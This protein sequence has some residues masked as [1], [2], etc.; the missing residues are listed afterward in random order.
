MEQSLK[1]IRE[2]LKI[3]KGCDLLS[4][5]VIKTIVTIIQEDDEI[6]HHRNDHEYNQEKY[7]ITDDINIPESFKNACLETICEIALL[8]PEL[9]CHS[10]GF[11]LII[12]CIFEKSIEISST[13][14]MVLLKILDF[15]NS[16][17]FIRNGFDLDSLISIYSNLC[18]NDDY[19]SSKLKKISSY[20]LQKISFL[21]S[22]LLKNF[23]GIMAYSINNFTSIKN[24]L[25]NLQKKNTRVRDLIL[26]LLLDALSIQRF[27]WMKNSPIGDSITRYNQY[28]HNETDTEIVEIK[29]S[30][31]QNILHH[32][33]GLLT[34]ILIKNGIFEYLTNIIEDN[35]NHD[36]K[37]ATL[38]LTSL[39]S[40]ANNYLPPEFINQNLLVPNL[41]SDASFKVVNETR[42]KFL[43]NTE[44]N[45]F[46]KS[47]IKQI[48]IQSKYNVDD[49][50]FK[51]LINNCKILTIKEYE[52]WNWTILS[53]LI[54]GPLTN[55]K[56]FDETLE[57][58][59]K[60]FKRLLSF[61]RPFK[62]RFSTVSNANKNC[63]RFINIGCQ[64]IEMLLNLDNG[65][66]Y[67]SS[68][69]LLPQLSEI[70]SQIDPFSGISSKDP[71]LS[72]KRIESTASIGYIR[73]I[74]VLS[75]HSSGIKMLEQWQ[76]FTLFL[77]IVLSTADSEANNVFVLTLFK[78]VDFTIDSQFR[79]TLKM[80]L[81]V[82]NFK[83]KY[84]LL[85]HLLPELIKIK[86]C[87]SFVIKI[88]V[89]N[90]YDRGDDIV[91]KSI[92][93]L[94]N[95]YQDDDFVNLES[96]IKF[97]PSINI[98]KKY[99]LGSKL[100]LNFLKFPVGFKYLESLGYLEM[101]FTEWNNLT[102]FKYLEKIN[103]IIQYQF[104]PYIRKNPHQECNET[105]DSLSIYFLQNLLSTEEGLNFFQ[106]G[107]GKNF[108]DSIITST[109]IFF[110]QI[111]NDENYLDIDNV[112]DQRNFVISA[113]KQN[114]W[115]IGNIA[116]GK[117]G[118]QLLDPMYNINLTNSI[119][120]LIIDNF[121][122]CPIWQIR[123]TCFY[124]LGMIGSTI[125]GIEIL[126]EFGWIS[127]ID[128]YGNCKKLSYPKFTNLVDIF[129]IDMI[130]PYRDTRYYHIFNSIPME[131]T[132]TETPTTEE[133]GENKEKEEVID[134]MTITL[135]HKILSLI[136]NIQA[137]LS[138]IENK[139]IRELNKLKVQYFEIFENDIELFL[140]IMKLID[141][142]NFSYYQRS[143]IF[144]LFL[145][146]SKNIANPS[147]VSI[148]SENINNVNNRQFLEL[149][150]RKK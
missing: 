43:G 54:Q 17:K 115:L 70:I 129:Q 20:K 109:E 145:K 150:V 19:N 3:E 10:G 63:S 90:L 75:Q 116:S 33:Q 28:L 74:G 62:Y 8:N 137:V 123:G 48:N 96:L 94:Y 77:N 47:S 27:P 4:V 9:V 69:K 111:S 13:C 12:N 120:N 148:T 132:D 18:D 66:K 100:L 149:L 24:L 141:K 107:I 95:F 87:E 23:N 58:A 76:F 15:E 142:G 101:K 91:S 51:T 65:I 49:N 119:I 34:L 103:S 144:N 60:F 41:S 16:R 57:K 80:C 1:L 124:V 31:S 146:T 50:E 110:H 133:D 7:G 2:F 86:E 45:Q 138:K 22:I 21:I 134:D 67:L 128:T 121:S 114:L 127:C 104:F 140:E 131:I 56:R 84:Y 112:N 78:Y 61:Y 35:Y 102:N 118:I 122:N 64:L 59:P 44:Y 89:E 6:N 98:L 147:S 79:N 39:Y 30:F 139:A 97:K 52:D 125:E 130:N 85:R 113:L 26:D 82:S 68:S 36:Q 83:I 32:H 40:M 99:P 72:K 92:E 93:I 81:K 55:P 29:D 135:R 136:T 117:Y 38:L 73:F 126:D 108:L 106:F 88:L 5:G 105:D 71:I 37:K 11:K 46:I 53:N 25:M 14:L 143:Y 42:Q